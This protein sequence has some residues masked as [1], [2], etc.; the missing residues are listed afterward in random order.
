M[1]WDS[2]TSSCSRLQPLDRR[3]RHTD[4]A[5]YRVGQRAHGGR[6]HTAFEADGDAANGIAVRSVSRAR[7]A[8]GD[9]AAAA[10]LDSVDGPL[11]HSSTRSTVRSI[12]LR[13]QSLQM[14]PC[15]LRSLSASKR[16]QSKAQWDARNCRT[17]T[18]GCRG[19]ALRS[20]HARCC[21]AWRDR[22][23]LMK[24]AAN[25]GGLCTQWGLE[26]VSPGGQSHGEGR[27]A[28]AR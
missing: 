5:S 19:P 15:G 28:R 21:R 7:A 24:E 6:G 18:T 9:P 8:R 14:N 20:R 10:R 22:E 3:C 17:L 13:R 26:D 12:R 4:A 2:A 16:G 27:R 23:R 25:S 1:D 11:W